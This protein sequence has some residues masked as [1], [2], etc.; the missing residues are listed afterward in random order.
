MGKSLARYGALTRA[1]IMLTLLACAC[2]PDRGE[3]SE[4]AQPTSEAASQ[5]AANATAE[6]ASSA[7]PVKPDDRGVADPSTYISSVY[8]R[9]A[10]S[11]PPAPDN[12]PFS[13]DL[14]RLIDADRSEEQGGVGR[15]DFDYWI[16]GQDY[17]VEGVDVAAIPQSDPARQVIVARFSNMGTEVVNHFH[18]QKLGSRW[19]IE[20]VRNIAGPGG[21][22]S[23]SGIL[24]DE[25]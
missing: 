6:A 24:K 7:A 14:R 3:G 8:A 1:T 23:L 12:H 22:W 25:S 21:G 11:D 16:D 19:F 17:E 10:A 5:A 13:P 9:Y 4:E 18:F 15:L 2:A 20:D